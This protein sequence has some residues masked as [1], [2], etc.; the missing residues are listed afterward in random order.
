MHGYAIVHDHDSISPSL[1]RRLSISLTFVGPIPSLTPALR[2]QAVSTGQLNTIL[3]FYEI[4]EPP[5]PSALSNVPVALLKRAIG[6]LAKTGRAQIIAIPD[7][8]GVR[9]FDRVVR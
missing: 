3:T 5:V 4:T 9:F 6:I 2:T 1:P 8:E 7:G